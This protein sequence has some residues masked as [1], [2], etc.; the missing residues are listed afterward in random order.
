M[1]T[2][3]NSSDYDSADLEKHMDKFTILRKSLYMPR[4][5]TPRHPKPI[6][7][8]VRRPRHALRQQTPSHEIIRPSTYATSTKNSKVA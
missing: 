2:R 4:L 6:N 5:A 1:Q 8:I 3:H 7:T